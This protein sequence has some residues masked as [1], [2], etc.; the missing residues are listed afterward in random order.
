LYS[1]GFG[2]RSMILGY[3]LKFDYAWPVENFKV[4]DP[5]IIVSLGLDF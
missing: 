1:Y 3:Y 2:F 4:K 5:R